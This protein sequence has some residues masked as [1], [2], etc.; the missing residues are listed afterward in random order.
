MIV[1][2]LNADKTTGATACWFSGFLLFHI[3]A[4]C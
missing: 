3:V 4:E 2:T 1:D